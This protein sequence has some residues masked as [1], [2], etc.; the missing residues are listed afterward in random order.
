MFILR[1]IAGFVLGYFIFPRLRDELAD[2]SADGGKYLRV[3]G[4]N[5]ENRSF[6]LGF[7]A[8]FLADGVPAR[9]GELDPMQVGEQVGD[10]L[11][12]V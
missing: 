10:G 7:L 9:G 12:S 11:M 2:G 1:E 6:L 3:A 8:H 4:E 5:A